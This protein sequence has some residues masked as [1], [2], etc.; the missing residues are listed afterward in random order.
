MLNCFPLLHCRL[1]VVQP[2][3]LPLMLVRMC[4]G[5]QRA[6]VKLELLVLA[7]ALLRLPFV[8][9]SQGVVE[10]VLPWQH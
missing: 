1:P 8:A 2:R 4:P 9:F 7:L 5:L 3:R 6:V 10:A